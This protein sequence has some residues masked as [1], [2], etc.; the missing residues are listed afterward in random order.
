MPISRI[1]NSL[2]LAVCMLLTAACCRDTVC[3]TPFGAGGAINIYQPDFAALMTVGGTVTINR[4]HK[5]IFVHRTTLSDFVAFECA[6]PH[7]HETRLTLDTDANSRWKDIALKC[8][9]CHSHFDI[10]FGNPCSGASVTNCPL[11]EYR[12]LFDGTILEIY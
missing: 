4:G 6:C 12:T 8:P 2:V 9:D 5:G 1:K 7:C 11:Y 3:D 10:W